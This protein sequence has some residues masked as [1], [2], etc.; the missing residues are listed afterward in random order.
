MHSW[1]PELFC[2][3]ARIDVFAQERPEETARAVLGRSLACVLLTRLHRFFALTFQQIPGN[4]QASRVGGR[5][6]AEV[7]DP[8]EALGRDVLQ[9]APQE[10][11]GS[12]GRCAGTG[13]DR[14]VAIVDEEEAL[15]G[16]A[17][18]MCIAAE[19]AVELGDAWEGSL[20]VDNP[21]LSVE[22]AL[23]IGEALV[24]G[25]LGDAFGSEV[26]LPL[27]ASPDERSDEGAAERSR[28]DA[29]R[30][31]VALAP[32]VRD[33]ALGVLAEPTGCHD[34]VDVRVV[35]KALGPSVKDGRDPNL[36]AEVAGVF[37]ETLDRPRGGSEQDPIDLA[38]VG[39]SDGPQLGGQGEHEVRIRD[40]QGAVDLLGDPLLLALA[41]ALRAGSVA[42]RVVGGPGV[43][44]GVAAVEMAAKSSRPAVDHGPHRPALL[45]SH[46]ATGAVVSG[47]VAQDLGN[48]EA[49]PNTR[50]RSH[51][52][53]AA[54]GLVQGE[55][56]AAPT[57]TQGSRAWIRR[58]H[59]ASGRRVS[60][61]WRAGGCADSYAGVARVDPQDPRGKRP[62]G[63]D[64]LASW[65]LRRQL[66]RGCARG[67]YGVGTQR[68]GL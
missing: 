31:Q 55:L 49:R 15:V 5:K 1:V 29:N 54:E 7:A 27:G 26:E 17:D 19:V 28:E 64:T 16:E 67:G 47:M 11:V 39:A 48:L 52:H 23:E 4:S 51:T 22:V 35:V 63:F 3:G 12:E 34:Q 24:V 37:G 6:E 13:P 38:Q 56:A 2:E 66:R 58:I 30:K 36:S 14:D 59:A 60:T 42:A 46:E 33:P 20:G 43:V 8:D 10:L 25:Q 44:A 18:T 41:L 61:L 32:A 53:S 45:L 65:R 62:S 68:Q 57:A 50:Q 21:V 9:E 40:G